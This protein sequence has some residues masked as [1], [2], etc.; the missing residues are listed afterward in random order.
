MRK[1]EAVDLFYP[2]DDLFEH[3]YCKVYFISV[4]GNFHLPFVK[5]WSTVH[6]EDFTTAFLD[7][8]SEQLRETIM[9]L[10]FNNDIGEVFL[11][12][13]VKLHFFLLKERKQLDF[14]DDFLKS[15]AHVLFEYDSNPHVDLSPKEY[16]RLGRSS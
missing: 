8:V 1:A 12:L 13:F 14:S 15:L 9:L 4:S 3:H 16:R 11:L 6:H 7:L 2:K 5:I 10:G